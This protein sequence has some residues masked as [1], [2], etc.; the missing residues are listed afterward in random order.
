M[1]SFRKNKRPKISRA[2]SFEGILHLMPGVHRETSPA[3]EPVLLIER[4]I[5]DRSWLMKRMFGESIRPRQIIL[6]ELGN[7]VLDQINGKRSVK[8]IIDGF[9]L[10]NGVHPREAEA[11]VVEFLNLL[12]ARNAIS[13]AFRNVPA[14]QRN[15]SERKP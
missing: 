5:A 10:K 13:V 14:G 7:G 6:D 11:C 15:G 1:F 4:R 12:M 2:E 8:A 9:A 3:G